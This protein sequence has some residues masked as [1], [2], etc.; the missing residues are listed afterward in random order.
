MWEHHLS[1]LRR[2]NIIISLPTAIEGW[3]DDLK[4]WPQITYTIIFSYFIDLVSSDSEA[5]N[6][7]R[8]SEAYQYLH[9]NK[10]GRVL[11]KASDTILSTLKQIA[12]AIKPHIT[13]PGFWLQ[14]QVQYKQQGVHVLHGK[15]DLA[16]SL[17]QYCG[18]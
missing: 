18:R 6:N 16:A 11:L 10:V 3:E 12:K 5:M 4:K 9:S 13:E 7:L 17:L 1:Q 2:D 14:R 15:A 8:S